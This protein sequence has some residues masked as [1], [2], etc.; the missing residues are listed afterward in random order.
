MRSFEW[1]APASSGK[2]LAGLDHL[3]ALA[4]VLVFLYH[5]RLFAHPAWIDT[6]GEFGWTGVDLFF[7]LSG[8][9]IAGQLFD[10][11]RQGKGIDL[12]TFYIKRSFRI[13]PGY[14]LMLA[15]YFLVP[16]FKERPGLAPLW[17]FLTFTQNFGLDLRHT[18]AFTHA[19][20]LCIEEQF[21]LLLPFLLL[22]FVRLK[23]FRYALYFVLALIAAGFT[24]RIYNWFHFVAP[25]EGQDGMYAVWY[26]HIYYPTYS[27]LEGL[28]TG[29]CIAALFA[30]KPL[31]RE[32]LIRYGNW[33]LLLSLVILTG[34]YFLCAEPVSLPA[35]VFGFF[36]IS[37]AYG[38]MVIAAVSPSCFL[39]RWG[40][41][42]TAML[43]TLSYA[44][45]LC[46]KAVVHLTQEWL[47]AHI[48]REGTWMFVWCTITSLAGGLLLHYIIEQPFARLRA[49]VLK[50]KQKET[51]SPASVAA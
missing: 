45:Y 33:F 50:K 51:T 30:F 36:I 17:K 1:M 34:A 15:L 26:T 6:V 18:R 31:L 22:L 25:M 23:I 8:F 2:K 3:R 44:V 39:Y 5:Y 29:V 14:L 49:M 9:L 16:G 47:S 43:A 19:W 24:I 42:V 21:Y 35:S 28:L 20:S 41:R 13:L 10:A 12:K 27:R 7:V 11:M 46:H 4:I 40:S 48:E 32:R 37:L 38:A